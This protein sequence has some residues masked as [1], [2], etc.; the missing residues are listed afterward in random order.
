VFFGLYNTYIKR[1]YMANDKP[2][3]RQVRT[4]WPFVS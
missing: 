1:F 3:A 2:Q 4:N